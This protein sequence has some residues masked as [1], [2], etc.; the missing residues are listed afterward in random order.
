[1][2]VILSTRNPTKTL[3]IQAIFA[4]SGITVISLDA[5]GIEGEALEDGRTLEANAQ[6]KAAFAHGVVANAWAMADDTGIFIDALDGIPGVD[7]A[8]WAGHG[9]STD[10]FTQFVVNEMKGIKNR[11]ATFKTVVCLISP[12]GKEHFFAGEEKGHLLESPRVPPQ[13]KMPY[14]P[15]FV[16]EGETMTWAEMTTEYENKISHRGKAFR[17]ARNF[18]EAL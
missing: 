8:Y 17:K 5:V 13:P 15:L 4:G 7:S 10:R 3:Q 1:M 14:S 16:P 11:A 9:V 18:L 6:K 12:E 2:N